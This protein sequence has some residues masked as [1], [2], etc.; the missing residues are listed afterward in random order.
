MFEEIRDSFQGEIFT[1]NIHQILY[2]TDGSVYREKPLAVLRPKTIEDI[3]LAIKY[4]SDNKAPIIPRTAGTSLAGQV[5]GKGIVIDV[6]RHF[7]K[8]LELNTEE[9]WVR[10]EPG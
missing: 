6:S 10:V 9:K 2:S 7:N 5:V 3:R 1:D 4:A 8:I